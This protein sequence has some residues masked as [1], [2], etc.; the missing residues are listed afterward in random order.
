MDQGGSQGPGLVRRHV[1][2]GVPLDLQHQ[3]QAARDAAKDAR[4]NPTEAFDLKD[5]A[6]A[7]AEAADAVAPEDAQD[8]VTDAYPGEAKDEPRQW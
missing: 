7:T 6:A 5:D 2:L 8:V 4:T 3:V 1:H